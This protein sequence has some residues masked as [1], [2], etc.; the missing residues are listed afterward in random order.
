MPGLFSIFNTAKSGLFS[1]QTA[2]NVT[3]HN[4]A[5]ANTDGYSRQRANMVTTTPYTMPSM[6][7]AA[8]A[9]QLGTGV[10]VES[11]Q[12]IRDSFL[13]YQFRVQNSI[14]GQYSAQDKVLSQVENVLNEPTDTSISSLLSGFFTSWQSLSKSSQNA[15]TVAQQA[16]QLTNDLNNVSSQL[17]KIKSDTNTELKSTIVTVNGYI[18]QLNQLNKQIQSV[19]IAGQNPNDLMDSRDLILDKLSNEFGI[20]IT[21]TDNNGIDVTTADSSTSKVDGDNGKAPL[22]EYGNPV[23]IVQTVNSLSTQ[24]STFSYVSAIEKNADGTYNVTYY[25][26]GDTTTDANKV[27]LTVNMT[28]DQAKELDECRVLWADS[29]GVAYSVNKVAGDNQIITEDPIENFSQLALFKPPAGELKGYMSVQ[30]KVDEYQDTFNKFAKSLALSVNAIISQSSTFVKD[31]PT[32][33]SGEGGINNFFVNGDQ[34]DSSKYSVTDEN[35]I[36]AANITLNVAILNDPSKIKVASKYDSDGNAVGT[37]TDGNRALAVAQLANSLMDIAGI[38][39]TNDDGT[40][41]DRDDR[42]E[43][44]KNIFTPNSDI[45]NVYSVGKTVGGSTMDNYYDDLVNKIGSDEQE[46]KNQVTYEA[47]QLSNF[48]QSRESV[49]GVSMDEE[50]TNLIQFQHCYQANAKMISTVDELLDV[51]INGLKR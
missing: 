50:M 42:S 12:R 31:N 8:G 28:E 17:T 15:S 3:S 6:D 10:T 51:V 4:I 34:K 43:L 39:I 1:Q 11:I 21:E 27:T 30:S 16:Y 49:S 23:N 32:D 44:V 20:G 48:D 19:T 22:D 47:T 36:T 35:N 29:D 2:I 24:A 14:S 37:T 18:N 5:N 25:K 9:G 40:S 13:D 45:G 41:A 33:G 7:G 26:K 46:S 38:N